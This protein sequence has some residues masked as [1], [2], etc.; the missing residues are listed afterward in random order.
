MWGVVLVSSASLP[1]WEAHLTDSRS[2]R[3]RK[4]TG[5]QGARQQDE[6]ISRLITQIAQLLEGG[7]CRAMNV[8]PVAAQ[9]DF[10][11]SKIPVLRQSDVG[12]PDYYC[13]LGGLY[14]PSWCSAAAKAHCR[15]KA[16]NL[17][18]GDFQT[19]HSPMG[20]STWLMDFSPI[21]HV[22]TAY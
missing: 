18:S 13:S 2:E 3:H 7:L 17:Q 21:M 15:P 14:P 5:L 11:E 16:C 9:Q 19:P 12:G 10:L 4:V 1:I 6:E 22:L 8:T 20:F